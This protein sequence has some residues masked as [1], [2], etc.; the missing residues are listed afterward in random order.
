MFARRNYF[1]GNHGNLHQNSFNEES[2]I[3]KIIL[4][5]APAPKG[6]D[7]LFLSKGRYLAKAYSVCSKTPQSFGPNSYLK[8]EVIEDI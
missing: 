6:V 8:F 7:L 2:Y 5:E 1:H 4:S 3:A